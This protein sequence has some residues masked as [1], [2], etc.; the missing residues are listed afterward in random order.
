MITQAL[1][2]DDHFRGR[3]IPPWLARF[4][5][6]PSVALHELLLGGAEVG[7][8]APV[9]PEILLRDWMERLGEPMAAAVDEALVEWIGRHWGLAI[10]PGSMDSAPLSATA[11]RRAMDLMA[12][13]PGLRRSGQT[14]RRLMLGD[15]A[16]LSAL[17]EGRSHDPE[18]RAWLALARHQ[19]DRDLLP[20]WWRL[21]DLPVDVPWYHGSYAIHGLRG[22]PEE[23]PGSGGGFPREAAQGLLRYARALAGRVE[24]GWLLEQKARSEFLRTARATWWAYNFPEKWRSFWRQTL[25]REGEE[26]DRVAG[27]VRQLDPKLRKAS[28]PVRPGRAHRSGGGSEGPW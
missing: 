24:D 4:E 8:L 3:W 13:S 18:G 6:E 12:S 22:L 7:H 15:R 27:W 14:L 1:K 26:G 10:L 19:E 20:E 25:P 5:D 11:W 16:F 9:E 2:L 28:F 23:R 21:V 17:R